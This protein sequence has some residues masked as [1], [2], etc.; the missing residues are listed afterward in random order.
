MGN[1]TTTPGPKFTPSQV[2]DGVLQIARQLDGTST[3]ETQLAVLVRATF[4]P[5]VNNRFFPSSGGFSPDDFTDTDTVG[6]VMVQVG[7]RLM[8]QGRLG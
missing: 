3:S 7:V 4:I 5:L 2:H 6:T 8:T 1:S